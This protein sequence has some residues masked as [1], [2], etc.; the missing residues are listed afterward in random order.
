MV[1]VFNSDKVVG[2]SDKIKDCDRTCN[3]A[4]GSKVDGYINEALV[5]AGDV[6]YSEDEED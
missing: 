2:H 5:A 1:T 6:G 4:H 3:H